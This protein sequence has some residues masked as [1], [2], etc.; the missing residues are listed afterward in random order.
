MNKMLL[1]KII[2]QH[3]ISVRMYANNIGDPHQ[4]RSPAFTNES[5][6]DWQLVT[7]NQIKMNG[8][9]SWDKYIL[10]MGSHANPA[11]FD[12]PT[13]VPH[14]DV[15]FSLMVGGTECPNPKRVHSTMF[16]GF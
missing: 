13:N 15:P 2:D 11:V 9:Y 8:I 16:S 6:T 4:S 3:V 7:E 12:V 10:P 1:R 5:N 14:T